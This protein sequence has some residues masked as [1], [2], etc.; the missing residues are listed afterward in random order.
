MAYREEIEYPEHVY[1]T[2]SRS[3]KFH[4]SQDCYALTR[5]QVESARI[6][7]TPR[8]VE[9][10]ALQRAQ[11]QKKEPCEFCFPRAWIGGDS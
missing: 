7:R 9:Y 10:M 3:S 5:G 4:A 2:T 11:K 8:R 6:G 1:A